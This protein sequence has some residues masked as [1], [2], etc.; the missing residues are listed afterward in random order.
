V[1]DFRRAFDLEGRGPDRRKRP[2]THFTLPGVPRPSQLDIEL[3][4]P[5]ENHEHDEIRP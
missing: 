4:F 2:E 1:N 5:W 3:P